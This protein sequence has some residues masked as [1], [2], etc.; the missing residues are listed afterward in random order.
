MPAKTETQYSWLDG[1]FIAASGANV[2]ILTHSLQY[3]SGIF[4]GLRAYK[5]K[6]GSAIF[7]LQDHMK[8]FLGSAKI[9]DIRMDYSEKQLCDAALQLV[10]KNKLESCYIRP[11]AFY[12]DTRIGMSPIGKKVSVFM[13]AVPFGAYFGGGKEKGIS[14]KVSS[15]KRINSS[16]MPPQAKACG[17]YANSIMANIEAKKCGADEAII[18]STNGYVAEGS[19]EN[20]FL[21]ENGRLLTPSKESDILPGITRDSII[22]LA[23]NMGIEA[24]ER[25]VHREELYTADEL[26]FTGTAAEVTSITMVDFRHIGNGKQGPI[27]KMLASKYADV[28]CGGD[29]E[30]ESWLC[31]I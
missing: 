1:K 2:P 30:F 17:N 22:K 7:R 16:I 20:V 28:V 18:L 8:R 21:V 29:S 3:A 24:E 27:T 6:K 4:E 15:W 9:C 11:F 25:E 14:C 10:K 23:E 13:A 12:N 31:Y 5:T 26:F 19:G